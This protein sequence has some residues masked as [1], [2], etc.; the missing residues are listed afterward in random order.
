MGTDT[1]LLGINAKE[2]EQYK[3]FAA[4]FKAH[5]LKRGTDR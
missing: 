3:D 2:L 5:R 1:S 4:A